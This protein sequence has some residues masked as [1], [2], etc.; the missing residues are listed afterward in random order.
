MA[1]NL[2]L[3]KNDNITLRLEDWHTP[4]CYSDAADPPNKAGVY[5]IVKYSGSFANGI[6]DKE[7]VYVGSSANLSV[8]LRSHEVYR[9]AKALLPDSYINFYFC[10]T[11]SFK[12]YEKELI[13]KINPRIN[14]MLIGGNQDG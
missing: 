12:A 14:V 1:R 6:P 8:R 4:N 5:I 9:I 11:G 13:R 7:I 10:E 3:Y 2:V